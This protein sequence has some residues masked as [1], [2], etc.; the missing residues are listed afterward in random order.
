MI[1]LVRKNNDEKT[2]RQ[3]S[4]HPTESLGADPFDFCHFGNSGRIPDH[5]NGPTLV[6]RVIHFVDRYKHS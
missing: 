5:P 1:Y 2:D 4:A 3:L 6:E